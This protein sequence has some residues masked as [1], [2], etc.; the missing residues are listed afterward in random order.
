M[1]VYPG[2]VLGKYRVIRELGVGAMGKVY[3]GVHTSLD[4]RVAIKVLRESLRD[5]EEC[6]ARFERE[7]RIVARLDSPHIV[8]I[9]DVDRLPDG[10]PYMVMELLAGED[11]GEVLS[12]TP[13]L[14]IATAV[15][16]VLQ[17]CRGVRAAHAAG[18]IHRDIKP[19]NLFLART[20]D[21]TILKLMDFGVS[22]EQVVG[23]DLTDTTAMMGTPR[24]MA[25]EHIKSAKTADARADVWALGVILYRCLSGELPYDGET[26]AELIVR[27]LTEPAVPLRQVAPYVSEA[28]AKVVEGALKK[29]VNE[30]FQSVDAFA[31]ALQ[32]AVGLP[33]T[34]SGAVVVP[35]AGLLGPTPATWGTASG[36]NPFEATR[37]DVSFAREATTTIGDRP[38]GSILERRSV[39]V[40]AV[41]GLTL[42]AAAAIAFAFHFAGPNGAGDT[43][44]RSSNASSPPSDNPKGIPVPDGPKTEGPSPNNPVAVPT[45]TTTQT[46]TTAAGTG[47]TK[48]PPGG[49]AAPGTKNPPGGTSPPNGN[50]KPKATADPV[51][52]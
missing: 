20:G 47:K 7:A 26:H 8:K 39:R 1:A 50:P 51:H 15:D 36:E 9:V 44:I 28:L 49:S 45:A 19:S 2:I 42:G 34:Q 10:L 43:S 48:A 5:D 24:Y 22:K 12:R 21:V 37:P 29:N 18:V 46:K 41:I 13:S 3:E 17:A 52:I 40:S 30:R 16:L 25:P 38:E 35:S 31:A 14:P 32:E 11:L 27:I 23:R 33:T 6:L 4:Q